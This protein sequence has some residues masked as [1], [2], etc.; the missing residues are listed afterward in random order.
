MV[1]LGWFARLMLSKS[2]AKQS[3][4][5]KSSPPVQG[6]EE[7]HKVLWGANQPRLYR[8]SKIKH[9]CAVWTTQLFELPGEKIK[10]DVR[11]Y[12]NVQPAHRAVWFL[13]SAVPS[14]KRVVCWQLPE[15]RLGRP[16]Y[17]CCCANSANP[18]LSP[19]AAQLFSLERLSTKLMK[20]LEEPWN[21]SST[22]RNQWNRIT[23]WKTFLNWFF[24][25]IFYCSFEKN[26]TRIRTIFPS[27]QPQR[28]TGIKT[29][30]NYTQTP[31]YIDRICSF[32][33]ELVSLLVCKR[34]I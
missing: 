33:K 15:R 10:H 4:P 6:M 13:I 7:I 18:R 32:G 34:I 28:W 31:S 3:K 23:I 9:T 16:A 30:G 11:Y 25:L 26:T 19:R 17:S 5:S 12:L 20:S 14:D 22:I 2:K 24:K 8:I 1:K 21:F 29:K 27:V